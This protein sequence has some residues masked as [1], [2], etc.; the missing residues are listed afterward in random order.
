MS[1]AHVQTLIELSVFAHLLRCFPRAFGLG[2][3]GPAASARLAASTAF[4][5]AVAVTAMHAKTGAT[6]AASALA[7]IK[8]LTFSSAFN[9]ST[10][11]EC[12]NS[13]NFRNE[14]KSKPALK[15]KP[16]TETAAMR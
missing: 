3:G 10:K 6:D 15:P 13:Y 1:L 4:R 11:G 12:K 8:Y 5:Q 2:G 9:R 16:P 7:Q 14:Q